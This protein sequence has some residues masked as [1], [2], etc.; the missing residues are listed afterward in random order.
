MGHFNADFTQ[1]VK[2]VRAGQ[3][4]LVDIFERME[5][6]FRRLETY[7]SVSLNEEMLYTITTIM[8]EVLYILGIA[9][10]EIRQSRLSK[11]WL[12]KCFT[13]LTELFLETYLKE[14]IGSTGIAD[15]LKRLDKLT[16]EEAW[17]ATAQVYKV[18]HTV[19]G[20]VRGVADNVLAVDNR[21]A[22]VDDRVASIDGRVRAIDDK[23]ATV[24]DSAHFIFR[25]SFKEVFN[26]MRPAMQKAPTDVDQVNHRGWLSPPDPSTN[27]SI[28]CRAHHKRFATWFFQGNT[29]REWKSTP[30]L[31]WIHGK[32]APLSQFLPHTPDIILY[33]AG[34]GK[35]TLWFV[36]H[37]LYLS[38]ITD[39]VYNLSVLRSSKISK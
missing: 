34:A 25:Q 1:T 3:D 35:S 28:A 22:C 33:L 2:G 21:V 8:V 24:I 26:P 23:V 18:T 10:K 4:A 19:D 13:V 5:M 16:Q 32:R 36:A 27:H 37:L 7:T 17:M 6:F 39:V 30:S 11:C 20:R 38:K 12:Y 14:L 15:A 9:T 29:Y 31:I